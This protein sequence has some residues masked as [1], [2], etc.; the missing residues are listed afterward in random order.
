MSTLQRHNKDYLLT[1]AYR[2]VVVVVAQLLQPPVPATPLAGRAERDRRDGR[3]RRRRRQ[4]PRRARD[5]PTPAQGH[6][7]PPGGGGGGGGG[8]W[9]RG[10]VGGG[11]RRVPPP[12]AV[13][14]AAGRGVRLH[15][16]AEDRD[17]HRPAPLQGPGLDYSQEVPDDRAR[18]SRR[19]ETS[20]GRDFTS[21]SRF[22]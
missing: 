18:L 14:A 6:A 11:G 1:L 7:A 21:A 16:A 15:A 9:R 5:A 22:A 3:V 2:Y 10:G 20:R 17:P 12:A 13:H 19:R 4:L 8:R